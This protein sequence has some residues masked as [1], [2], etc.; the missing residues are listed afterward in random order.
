MI[1][2]AARTFAWK[3]NKKKKLAEGSNEIL[4]RI[5]FFII[6]CDRSVLACLFRDYEVCDNWL[7]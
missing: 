1:S 6:F 2:F 4:P 5:L 3:E 7:F